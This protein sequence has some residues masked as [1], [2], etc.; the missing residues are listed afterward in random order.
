MKADSEPEI[1]V[2]AERQGASPLTSDYL[3][4]TYYDAI[5][6]FTYHYLGNPED[7]RDVTQET[8]LRATLALNTSQLISNERAW[9]YAIA[10]NL[11]ADRKRSWRRFLDFLDRR[12]I[13]G[14]NTPPSHCD[15]LELSLT[16]RQ[17]V[18]ALPLRQREVFILRHWH[19]FSTEE[20][21]RLLQ[22]DTGTVKSHL[23]RAV[24]TLK[25]ALLSDDHKSL[26]HRE[27]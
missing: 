15:V 12:S 21:A 10:R 17:L 18:K 19:D 16:I 3:I 6:K 24:A 14:T 4:Q 11:C 26:L 25:K 8:F 9:L 22:V 23:S 7:A 1:Q 27:G 13:W 5:L 20:T 2:S